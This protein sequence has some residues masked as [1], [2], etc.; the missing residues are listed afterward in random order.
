MVRLFVRCFVSSL[1]HWFVD[2]IIR[3]F[4]GPLVRSFVRSLA[5]SFVRSFA[6][7]LFHRT[8][9]QVG[10]QITETRRLFLS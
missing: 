6:C 4:V 9:A 5:R 7:W 2:S 10:F 1:V 3:W 8:L